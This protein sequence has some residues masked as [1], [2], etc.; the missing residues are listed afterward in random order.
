MRLPAFALSLLVTAA[1][2]ADHDH[3]AASSGGQVTLEGITIAVA[4]H[5]AITP[6]AEAHL[7]LVLSPATAAPKALR[8]WIGPEQGR[9]VS[10]TRVGGRGP[11]RHAH[12]DVP[13]PLPA[14]AQL[15]IELEPAAGSAT[16]AALPL[17]K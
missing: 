10:K 12:V 15:W 8:V 13:K 17:P 6:G 14:G 5:G 1:G 2:A 9:G 16:R 4:V 3:G 7:D 11:A